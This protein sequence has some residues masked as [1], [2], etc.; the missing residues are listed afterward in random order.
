MYSFT[1]Q[2]V[3]KFTVYQ[4]VQR[5]GDSH[6][7]KFKAGV[8]P[9]N[10]ETVNVYALGSFR[11]SMGEFTQ[12]L[13]AGSTTLDLSITNFPEGVVSTE[14]VLSPMAVRYCVSAEGKPYTKQIAMVTEQSSFTST[15]KCLAFVLTGS[16]IAAGVPIGAG[17]YVMLDP[18][19]EVTGSGKLLVVT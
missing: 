9:Q 17:A 14:E 2:T 1:R 7:K 11:F 3:G 4:S 12:D 5:A 18:G 15:A 10:Q 16:V 19:F 8:T 13:P 6:Q